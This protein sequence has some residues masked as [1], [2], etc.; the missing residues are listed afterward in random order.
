MTWP[1][2]SHDAIGGLRKGS[3]STGL[4]DGTNLVGAA[5]ISTAAVEQRDSPLPV[6]WRP[7]LHPQSS[8]RRPL[9][10]T[11]TESVNIWNFLGAASGSLNIPVAAA[12]STAR[13]AGEGRYLP[14]A[15]HPFAHRPA[16]PPLVAES[17]VQITAALVGSL[18]NAWAAQVIRY[19][20]SSAQDGAFVRHG[21]GI[22]NTN[23]ENPHYFVPLTQPHK[24]ARET[25]K[26]F[27]ISASLA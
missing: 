23:T 22:S 27:L 7:G 25:P 5:P 8:G 18:A 17:F 6:P 9:R 1:W 10:L 14:N 3:Q 4:Q 21:P 15:A 26:P 2:S 16:I 12:I 11:C 13:H 19:H 24:A 20:E